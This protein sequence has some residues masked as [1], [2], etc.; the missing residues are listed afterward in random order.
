M[1]FNFIKLNIMSRNGLTYFN[2]SNVL[3][4]HETFKT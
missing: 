3:D 4:Q 1:F 2:V